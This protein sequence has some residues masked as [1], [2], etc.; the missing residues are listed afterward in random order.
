MTKNKEEEHDAVFGQSFARYD[1]T[2]MESF[3]HPFKT[4]FEA[5]TIDP[6]N[7]F[8]GRRCLDAGCGGGRGS[9]FMLEHGASHVSAVDV[10]ETNVKTAS[11]NMSIFGREKYSVSHSS[12]EALPFEDESF[13]FVWCYGVIQHTAEPD[14]C[15]REITRVLKTSGKMFVFVYG[16]GGLYWYAIQ[17][18]RQILGN[19]QSRT[20]FNSLNL[21]K[22]SVNE[23]TTFMDDWKAA[24]LRCYTQNEFMAR[25]KNFGMA[26][27]APFLY[28]ATHD[29]N[30]RLNFYPE[31]ALWVGEGDLRYLL[32]K[33]GYA[34]G[35]A[36]PLS[37]DAELQNLKFE[38]HILAKFKMGFD[39]LE[40][41]VSENPVLAIQACAFVHGELLPLMTREGPLDIEAFE[42]ALTRALSFTS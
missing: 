20:C 21:L 12:L 1:S 4:R 40:K 8:S 9:M 3:I 23:F 39:N 6:S 5:N 42:F 15:L 37:N 14:K 7:I 33:H 19:V 29:L 28:G 17:R 18:F 25:L 38:E 35:S 36:R 34:S 31:D 2:Q 27:C 16:S 24:Y 26:E 11:N 13:D 22:V 41:N 30:H 32:E 10:S